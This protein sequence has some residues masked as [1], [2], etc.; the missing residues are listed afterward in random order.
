MKQS[1]HPNNCITDKYSSIFIS[2]SR[3]TPSHS[4]HC[5]HSPITLF[6]RAIRSTNSTNWF[7]T[8]VTPLD[9]KISPKYCYQN[10][11]KEPPLNKFHS[12]AQKRRKT[13]SS[14]DM[15]SFCVDEEAS[16][17]F[18]CQY[19]DIPTYYYKWCVKKSKW[20]LEDFVIFFPISI[21]RFY[22]PY[23][24]SIA[25]AIA[26]FSTY[27]VYVCVDWK[28]GENKF[29]SSEFVKSVSGTN[30]DYQSLQLRS[31]VNMQQD[32]ATLVKYGCSLL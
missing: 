5:R 1:Y 12:R 27:I 3:Q 6:P 20:S 2:F 4:H 9:K 31:N 28:F 11:L 23:S 10:R 18:V 24:V 19:L 8:P 25:C 17:S 14:T 29:N 32:Y 22:G 30:L 21:T 16:T 13:T 26:I 7:T 15:S